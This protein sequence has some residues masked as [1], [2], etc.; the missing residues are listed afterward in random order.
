MPPLIGPARKLAAL[1][2]PTLRRNCLALLRL[3]TCMRFMCCLAKGSGRPVA[4][5]PT[6]PCYG[7]TRLRGDKVPLWPF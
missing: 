7:G 1:L 3:L 6:K 5:F 2:F 4:S